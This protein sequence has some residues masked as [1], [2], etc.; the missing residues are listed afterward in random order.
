MMKGLKAAGIYDSRQFIVSAKHGQSA[1]N[2]VKTNKP[3][4]FADLVAA[5]PGASTD[6][7]A[8]AIASANNCSTGPCGFVQDD[9]IALIWLGDQ[10][11][12]AAAAAFLYGKANAPFI[13]DGSAGRRITRNFPRPRP[14][15]WDPCLS[16]PPH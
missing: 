1:I 4:H 9:D 15:P 6:P 14:G 16:A 8:L 5:L 13:D 2:P 3:G 10:T 12:T 11:K 7:G